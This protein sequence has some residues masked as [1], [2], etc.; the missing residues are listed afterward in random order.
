M[1]TF[2]PNMIIL[3]RKPIVPHLTNSPSQPRLC[4]NNQLQSGV[5]DNAS[6]QLPQASLAVSTAGSFATSV[7]ACGKY[8]ASLSDGQTWRYKGVGTL[9]GS[10]SPIF[11]L[12]LAVDS[13]VHLHSSSRGAQRGCHPGAHSSDELASALISTCLT[14]SSSP[15]LFLEL[16]SKISYCET[17]KTFFFA[18][19]SFFF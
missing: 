19:L 8:S 16:L 6:P 13:E 9:W 14:F 11:L 17:G 10:L 2:L 5:I 15:L 7:P 18:A 12:S 1:A 3:L 4:C